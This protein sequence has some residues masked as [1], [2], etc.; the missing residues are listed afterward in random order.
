MVPGPAPGPSDA[1]R[2]ALP[3]YRISRELG[4]GGMG[5]VYEAVEESTGRSVALKVLAA[6][7]DRDEEAVQRF[8]REGKIA[9]SLSHPRSTFVYDAGEAEGRFFITM[10][11][12]PGGTV[13][14]VIDRDGKLSVEEA[15]G[16]TLDMLEG[17]EAAHKI[18]VVH[19]DIKPSNCFVSADGRVKVG[20]FGISK[21]L[22]TDASLTRT[23]AFMGTPMFAAPEQIRSAPVD[24]RTDIYSTGATLFY[25]LTA[26]P[27]FQGDAI[28]VVA[29]I[30]S[31][32]PP[33]ARE[34]EPEVPAELSEIIART[35]EKDPAAR[36]QSTAELR[37]ALMPFSSRNSAIGDVGRRMAAFFIDALFIWVV[38]SA[39]LIFGSAL[40][41]GRGPLAMVTPTQRIL[42]SSLTVLL[43]ILYFAVMESQWGRGVGKRLMGLRVV[44]HRGTPPRFL[45]AFMRAALIPGLGALVG[46]VG[47]N[48][49]QVSL[50]IDPTDLES[51]MEPVAIGVSLGFPI[52]VGIVNLIVISSMRRANGFLGW[53]ETLTNTRVIRIPEETVR[54]RAVP[55][56]VPTHDPID[57]GSQYVVAGCL[58]KSPEFSMYAA[59]DKTLGRPVWL[60]STQDSPATMWSAERIAISRGTRQHL[61]RNHTTDDGVRW[62]AMEAISGA[63]FATLKFG[64][65]KLTWEKARQ[66]LIDLAEELIAGSEDGTLPKTLTP[67][68]VWL[69][70]SGRLKLLDLPLSAAQ[71]DR[72]VDGA[73]PLLAALVGNCREVLPGKGLD[74]LNELTAK[75]DS[76]ETLK[77]AHQQLE[78]IGDNPGPLSWDERMGLLA[79]SSSTEYSLLNASMLLV[80][81]LCATIF[82][83]R[84][85]LYV[86]AMG[87]PAMLGYFFQGGPVFRVAQVRPRRKGRVA[88]RWRCA[89]RS[90]LAW[91]PGSLGMALMSLFVVE[92]FMA[93]KLSG[94]IQ[95]ADGMIDFAIGSGLLMVFVS[96][97]A[98]AILMPRKGIQDWL[99]GTEL[100]SE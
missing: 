53:H 48:L 69:D 30:V 54:S 36:P 72:P 9:A 10:E 29:D 91:L 17:L 6:G 55:V 45:P 97:S 71:V 26:R 27:P 78:E 3:G 83:S 20:D 28:Q 77:W 59:T 87:I 1:G 85:L 89:W 43:T 8:L 47:R 21:S 82:G 90:F 19:R 11:L 44:S 2:D 75:P 4:R 33:T 37:L 73:V 32:I 16:Y 35:M 23:G 70:T 56:T 58:H 18:D 52:L 99:S 100:V 22:I 67:S 94:G 50:G 79:M 31:D 14:D 88:S 24:A 7:F 41:G 5:V 74:F 96:G 81:I 25:M 34:I 66:A 92:L 86:I 63:P 51:S 98:L 68:Q 76:L 38:T 15:V 46:G 42:V 40:S 60:M 65:D 84:M 57:A 93:D 12:M 62:D 80:G 95:E 13:K 61:L 49:L 39:I 64:H